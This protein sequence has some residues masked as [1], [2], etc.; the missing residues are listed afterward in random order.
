M[1]EKQ[2]QWY[3][4]EILRLNKDL[5]GKAKP[6]LFGSFTGWRSEPMLDL[7]DFVVQH[8]ATP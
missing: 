6:I 2:Q 1:I 5:N 3:K 8:D 4:D 7:Y